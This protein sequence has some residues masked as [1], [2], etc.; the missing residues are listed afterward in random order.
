[1]DDGIS[2]ITRNVG[3]RDTAG[4]SMIR[5]PYESTKADRLPVSVSEHPKYIDWAFR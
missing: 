5:L 2:W 4:T 1:V 3:G